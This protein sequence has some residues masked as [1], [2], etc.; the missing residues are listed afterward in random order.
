MTLQLFA[1]GAIAAL[2]AGVYLP[3]TQWVL[4]VGIGSLVLSLGLLP[5]K[6]LRRPRVILLGTALALLWLTAYDA[7]FQAPAEDL[8][9]RT[10]RLEAVVTDWP[11]ATDYGLR[12]PVKAGEED[13]RKVS[14]LLYCE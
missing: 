1:L 6:K 8:E 5:V 4:P 14:A 12:V 11:E 10:V 13:G 7:I 2:L 9:N 3:W